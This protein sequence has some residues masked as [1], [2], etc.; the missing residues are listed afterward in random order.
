M[1]PSS[2]FQKEKAAGGK[3]SFF[4]DQIKAA[5]PKKVEK[6]KTWQGTGTGGD[7][8]GT[9]KF[10]GKTTIKFDGPPPKQKSISDLP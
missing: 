8:Y 2:K 4:E 1:A 3:K 5:A 9:G 7:Q 10:K 6:K